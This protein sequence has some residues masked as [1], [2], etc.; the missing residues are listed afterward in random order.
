MDKGYIY[1]AINE[2]FL[3]EDTQNEKWHIL[4]WLRLA[5]IVVRA[6]IYVWEGDSMRSYWLEPSN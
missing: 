3:V 5:L 1:K 4:G 6:R 2:R